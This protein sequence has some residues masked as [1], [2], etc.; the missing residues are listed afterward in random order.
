[1]AFPNVSNRSDQT[2]YTG[3]AGNGTAITAPMSVVD[4]DGVSS[5]PVAAA[6]A[7]DSATTLALANNLR[8]GL[9]ALG[10]FS[11]A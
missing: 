10:L 2:F 9:I 11:A 5:A 6:V 4:S 3:P 7:T 1:M 8:A